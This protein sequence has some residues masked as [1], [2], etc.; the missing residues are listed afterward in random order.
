MLVSQ[1]GKRSSEHDMQIKVSG[2][3]LGARIV[4][5]DLG[6][7]RSNLASWTDLSDPEAHGLPGAGRSVS[8]RTG[9]PSKKG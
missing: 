9:P 7:I 5:L 4:D 3:V 2:G 6:T 1:A 8:S